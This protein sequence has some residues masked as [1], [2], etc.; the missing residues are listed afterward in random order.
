M[1]DLVLQ[2]SGYLSP[3]NT[4]TIATDANRV[5]SGNAIALHG[6]EFKPITSANFDDSPLI[7]QFPSGTNVSSGA[8]IHLTSIENMGF[9]ITGFLDLSVAADQALVVPLTQLPRTKWYKL[10]YFSATTGVITA[11]ADAGGGTTTVTSAA[12]GLSNSDSVV[13]TGTTS[14]NGTFTVSGV[15]TNTFVISRTFVADDATGNWGLGTSAETIKKQLI[16][17]L[18]DDTF[19]A[20]EVTAFGLSGK[21]KHLHVMIKSVTWIHSA[22]SEPR[23]NYTIT[24]KVTKG[25]T[26]TV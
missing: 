17:H 18:A 21:Y 25:G 16:F 6:V 14:Y 19:T 11:F 1:A 4:G 12:H 22:M 13:I 26:S 5:N 23:V 20:G 10:L 9:T 24:G 8:D 7:G 2:D 15:A 3:T